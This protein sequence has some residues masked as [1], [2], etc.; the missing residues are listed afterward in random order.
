MDS[1]PASHFGSKA[2]NY[3][4]NASTQMQIAEEMGNLLLSQNETLL[5]RW[6]DIGSGPG[7]MQSTF[8]EKAPTIQPI[9]FDI[10]EMSLQEIS[11]RNIRICGNMDE[12]P[13][14]PNCIDGVIST[15]SIQW[16]KNITSLI[17]SL[18]SIL[19]RDGILA[20]AVFT[21][22]TLHNLRIAQE[23]FSL[24]A[25]VTFPTEEDIV[26]ILSENGFTIRSVK[27][28]IYAEEFSRGIDALKAISQIGASFHSGP[29]L[30]PVKLKEFIAFYESLSEKGKT[31]V[32][33]YAVSF[34][35]ATAGN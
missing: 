23:K 19:K 31:H 9:Y 24:Q 21:D 15:S 3:I 8:F 29:R 5:G 27:R 25:P 16:S 33:K 7:V 12:L 22:K 13:L 28:I 17:S 4:A 34:F 20:L 6:L 1:S 26:N 14:R 30:S 11:E 10:S 35:T 2:D 32:N 18:S